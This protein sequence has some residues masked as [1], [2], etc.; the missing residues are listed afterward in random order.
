MIDILFDIVTATT[1]AAFL[2]MYV[3]ARPR[4]PLAIGW[5]TGVRTLGCASLTAVVA[6]SL[7]RILWDWFGMSSHLSPH[8]RSI[9]Y[10]V[11]GFGL[12][13]L[14]LGIVLM[15]A[16]LRQ[17]LRLARIASLPH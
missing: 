16:D 8:S 6:A 7:L 13:F 1:M 11:K 12:T 14:G 5:V 4:K 10:G 9:A 15:L 17:R 2:A 3:R